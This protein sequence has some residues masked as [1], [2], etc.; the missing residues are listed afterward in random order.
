MGLRPRSTGMHS[1]PLFSLISP[2]LG[3][4]LFPPNIV[5][6]LVYGLEQVWLQLF[7]IC[8]R[9]SGVESVVRSEEIESLSILIVTHELEQATHPN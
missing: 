6:L 2:I 4:Y 9:N 1:T 5:Y 3:N 8:P 7:S